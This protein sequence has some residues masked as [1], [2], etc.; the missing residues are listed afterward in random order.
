MPVVHLVTWPPNSR[1]SFYNGR[2]E[3]LWQASAYRYDLAENL[4]FGWD[5]ASRQIHFGFSTKNKHWT[6]WNEENISLIETVIS[7]TQGATIGAG[8]FAESHAFDPEEVLDELHHLLALSDATRDQVRQSQ[9]LYQTVEK[10][11]AFTRVALDVVASRDF[12][13]PPRRGG[14]ARGATVVD[15][16]SVLLADDGALKRLYQLIHEGRE[17]V[18]RL[19]EGLRLTALNVVEDRT[20]HFFFHWDLA[21]P[22]VFLR[23]GAKGFDAVLTNPPRE[24]AWEC[25]RGC[26]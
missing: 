22:E 15:D 4:M 10:Q 1:V 26:R 24:R 16:A 20:R 19:P 18:A 7:P 11:L 23:K 13:N 3:R 5:K 6:D 17:Q 8:L 12:S 21:F 2:G 9:A 14:R 25:G